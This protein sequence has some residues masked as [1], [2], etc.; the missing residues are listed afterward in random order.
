MCYRDLTRTTESNS[1]AD[2]LILAVGSHRVYCGA[3]SGTSRLMGIRGGVTACS[4][5]VMLNG[6][7][8][9]QTT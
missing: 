2:A 4:R 7:R 8:F 9:V 5:A 6:V 3:L 1:Y